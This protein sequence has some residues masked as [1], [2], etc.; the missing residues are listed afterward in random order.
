MEL[1]LSY[2]WTMLQ[3]F[4]IHCSFQVHLKQ[5]R[6]QLALR[7]YKYILLYFSFSKWQISALL[8]RVTLCRAIDQER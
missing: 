6:T 2:Y 8:H 7:H 5:P 3:V 4:L 1:T